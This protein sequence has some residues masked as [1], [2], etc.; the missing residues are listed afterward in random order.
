MRA[1]RYVECTLTMLNSA[2]LN[3]A[4]LA[5]IPKSVLEI[6]TVKSKE[7]EEDISRKKLGFL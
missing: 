2:S 7:L 6:A 5:N 3:V 1:M 4:K